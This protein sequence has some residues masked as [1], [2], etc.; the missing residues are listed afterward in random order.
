M[1]SLPSGLEYIDVAVRLTQKFSVFAL[2]IDEEVLTSINGDALMSIDGEMDEDGTHLVRLPLRTLTYFNH[3]LTS[4]Q[5]RPNPRLLRAPVT[6]PRR[7][8][9][10]RPGG[11]QP[12]QP[13]DAFPPFPPMPDMTT[14]HEGD[15]QCVIVDAL[16]AI[17]A[18]VSR[19]RCSSRKSVRA[20]SP[21]VAGPSRQRRGT[22]SDETTDE[23]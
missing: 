23:D 13:E 2:S 7:C 9:V 18:R 15:F 8:T 5:F 22:S 20:I 21:S 1:L 16:T 10:Q 12:H 6:M 19:C 4:I 11:P 14:R 3:G 17:W